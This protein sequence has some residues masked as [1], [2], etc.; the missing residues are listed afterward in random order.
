MAR[1][2]IALIALVALSMFAFGHG[3][4]LALEKDV[5]LEMAD[6][7]HGLGHF[8]CLEDH[9]EPNDAASKREDKTKPSQNACNAAAPQKQICN[10]LRRG[11][12]LLKSLIDT[13]IVL[14][15]FRH[16]HTTTF[17]TITKRLEE[18]IICKVRQR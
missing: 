18:S 8:E 15:V 4:K 11:I 10:Q 17:E 16:V 3:H 7:F 2:F 9:E 13:R 1:S 6:A 5:E 14:E 12:L